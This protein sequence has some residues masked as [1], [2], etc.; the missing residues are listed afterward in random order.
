MGERSKDNGTNIKRAKLLRAMLRLLSSFV[1]AI[2]VVGMGTLM[3]L[4]YPFIQTIITQEA[5]NFLSNKTGYQT[6]I[7]NVAIDWFDIIRLQ[8][9]HVMDS[10]DHEMIYL[11]ELLIDYRFKTI[12]QDGDIYLDQVVLRN[13]KVSLVRDATLNMTGF[14]NGIQRA[15]KPKTK[16]K[17]KRKPKFHI[18]YGS[19]ENMSFTYN[20]PEASFFEEGMFDYNHFG[21]HEIYGEVSDF[22]V[23]RDTIELQAHQLHATENRTQKKVNELHARFRFT[24]KRMTFGDLYAVVGKSILRDSLVLAYDT[25]ADFSN[26]NQQVEILADIRNSIVHTE[27]LGIF[28]EYM[29][30]KNDVYQLTGKFRGKVSNLRFYD[31]EMRFGKSSLLSGDVAFRGL[32]ALDATLMNLN[33]EQSNV[34]TADLRPYF[35]D[36]QNRILQKFGRV[37]F[38]GNFIGFYND[39]VTDGTFETDLGY[40]E[41][42]INLETIK[43]NYSGKIKTQD[44]DLGTLTEQSD[45]IGKIDMEGKI[46]GNGLALSR[47]RFDFNGSVNSID[48]F[49]Y[50]YK[51]VITNGHFE[52]G[53]FRG[54]MKVNDP[55]IDFFIDGEVNIRDETFNFWAE[56]SNAYLKNLGIT[57]DSAYLH[58]NVDARFN[59]LDWQTVAGRLDFLD[60]RVGYKEQGITVE[61]LGIFTEKDSVTGIREANIASE[62]FLLETVGTFDLLDLYPDALRYLK[63]FSEHV[64]LDNIEEEITKIEQK[65]KK[66]Q[67]KEEQNPESG[68]KKYWMDFDLEIYDINNAIALFD[69]AIYLSP[70]SKLTGNLSYGDTTELLLGYKAD[71][72]KY[73]DYTFVDD[74]LLLFTGRY[75]K[76][77]SDTLDFLFENLILSEKQDLQGLEAEQLMFTANKLNNKILFNL[78]VEHEIS[79]DEANINGNIAFYPGHYD[80]NLTNT[81][82]L[83]LNERWIQNGLNKIQFYEDSLAF[84]DVSFAN[85]KQLL[86]LDGILSKDASAQMNVILKDFSLDILNN[87][88]NKTLAGR[89]NA[90]VGIKD[91]YG[92]PKVVSNFLVDSLQV[93]QF[94]LGKLQNLSVWDNLQEKLQ[95]DASLS[96][97]SYYSIDIDGDYVPNASD[98][99]KLDLDAVLLEAPLFIAEPFLK[100]IFTEIDGVATGK[101]H[102]SGSP[103]KPLF[104][105]FL[106]LQQGNLKVNYLNTSYTFSDTLFFEDELLSFKD[107]KVSDQEGNDGILNGAIFQNKDNGYAIDLKGEMQNLKV[108]DTKENNNALYYGTAIGDGT[109]RFSGPFNDLAINIQAETNKGTKIYI[110]L[111]GSE[112]VEEQDFITFTSELQKD[113]TLLDAQ[114]NGESFG[115][116]FNMDL[117]I[118]P[119]AYCEIIFDKKAGDI[120][121]GNAAGNLRMEIDTKG[122][123]K[124]FGDVEIVRGAYN[125][126]LLN[127]VDKK[128]TINPGSLIKWTGDP[129]RGQMDVKATYTQ[130]AS[131][132]PILDADSSI[133]NQ[134]E[135]R[136]R[137]PVD[138]LLNL[139]GELL[140]P[141][142]DFD[143]DI[144]NYPATVVA[145]GFTLSLESYVAAF[146]QRIEN[147]EQELNRQVFSLIV[148]RKL[149]PED[150][151]AGISGSAATGVSELLANQLS[152]WISQVDENLEIDLDLGGLDAEALN[153]FQLRLSYNFF[154]GRLRVTRAGEFTNQQNQADASSILGDITVEYLLTPAGNLR[155]RMYRKSN[156]NSF[157]TGIE[158]NST[159]GVSIMHTKSFDRLFKKKKKEKKEKQKELPPK[160]QKLK[161]VATREKDSPEE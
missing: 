13:G 39:F 76:N 54:E 105:G 92:T 56:V 74:S 139:K 148:L 134:P 147:D 42:D 3:F 62:L 126:T 159:A 34:N 23:S 145:G 86:L 114:Q 94:Y 29:Q 118:T 5:A 60:S 96:R 142:V 161:E 55:N 100:E 152:Y 59:G 12:M 72:L 65:N 130:R 99:E 10:A 135:V 113:S 84:K 61:Q 129:Y 67:Q 102:I 27:D 115:L 80:I 40:L 48:I 127:V 9:V 85:D 35:Y 97:P 53:L 133:V 73:Q 20:K 124:M 28:T 57:Q 41:T 89:L 150:R 22:R 64:E 16:K 123:F 79:Q 78:G 81:N 68:Y 46:Q 112:D 104:N 140:Q 21:F 18:G 125:F 88:S 6:K 66:V 32:P 58:T 110:P 155:L 156:D 158:N 17:K 116:E 25:V 4:Q 154:D 50:K 82:F 63:E 70:D 1:F 87:Y 160:E 108:L 15:F 31:M 36:E 24:K 128:F 33:F 47:A 52:E 95:I 75:K 45:V 7:G 153:A 141:I 91:F 109:V 157:N 136:R 77:D 138:V 90:D 8:D 117:Q 44:F 98:K 119:D 143:I 51:N 146:E 101:V 19:L 83:F 103:T 2:L 137:Y 30:E 111:E 11:E 26:F 49:D 144:R 132:S 93:D 106:D 121:R 43:N 151:F 120:I 122:E 131:L 149:S 107:F 14:I 69:E 38:Q 71:T 37:K